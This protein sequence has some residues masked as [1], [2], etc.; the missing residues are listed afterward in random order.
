MNYTNID[1][2]RN[3]TKEARV[4]QI[5]IRNIVSGI[6]EVIEHQAKKGRDNVTICPNYDSELGNMLLKQE[7]EPLEE[8]VRQLREFGYDADIVKV[9]NRT[10]FP[11]LMPAIKLSISW[12]QPQKQ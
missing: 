10:P 6:G 9:M 2:I 5:R 4:D 8:V 11:Q 12:T 7:H 3:L 1:Y